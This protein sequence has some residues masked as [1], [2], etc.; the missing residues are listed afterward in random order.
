MHPDERTPLGNSIL[1]KKKKI[2][3]NLINPL[4]LTTKFTKN[5]VE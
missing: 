4:N 1:K 5:T 3:R 2:D